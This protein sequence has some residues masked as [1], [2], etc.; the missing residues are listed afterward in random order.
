MLPHRA[1]IRDLRINYNTTPDRLTAYH[2]KRLQELDDGELVLD[3]NDEGHRRP[4]VVIHLA[5]DE[6]FEVDGF[7]R[8]LS[9][10]DSGG[11][12]FYESGSRTR[13]NAPASAGEFKI[14]RPPDEWTRGGAEYLTLDESGLLEIVSQQLTYDSSRGAQF[15]ANNFVSLVEGN[16]ATLL[17]LLAE[18]SPTTEIVATVTFLGFDGVGASSDHL[19][20]TFED[21][22]R[23]NGPTVT[24]DA[25]GDD[26]DSEYTDHRDTV[27]TLIR[28]LWQ[29]SGR[30]NFPETEHKDPLPIPDYSLA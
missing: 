11:V 30:H 2:E 15:A 9:E 20:F 27:D 19:S 5:P 21:A 6:V 17:G 26:Y 24:F 22:A 14:S 4:T 18:D 28:P 1:P 8:T 16:L 12:D 25:L 3:T 13:T 23:V 10:M 7:Y 29:S